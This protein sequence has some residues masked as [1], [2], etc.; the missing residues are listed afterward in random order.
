[1]IGKLNLNVAPFLF[2][3]FSAHIFP[4]WAL[5]ILFEINNPNPVPSK[6]FV[7]NFENSLGKISESM[8]VPLSFILTIV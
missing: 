1:L 6:D 3:L 5:I 8:P 2:E 4:P 7:A